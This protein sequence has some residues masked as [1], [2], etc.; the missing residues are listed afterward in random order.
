MG[1]AVGQ[2]THR[3][4]FADVL[5]VPEFRALWFADVQS[6][7]GDQIGRV[8]LSV[9]VFERTRSAGLTGLTYALTYIP[10]IVGGALLS[11]L[12]D[13]LRRRPFMIWCDLS[14]MA[15]LLVM[16]WPR[17]PLS[18]LAALLVVVVIVGRPFQAAENAMLPDILSGEAY[19]VGSGLRTT[20]MQL[21]QLVGFAGGGV[22]VGTVGSHW[23]LFIDAVTFAIS[24]LLI[25]LFVVDRPTPP[26]PAGAEPESYRRTVVSGVRLV[27]GDARLRTVMLLAWLAAFYSVPEGLAAPYAASIGANTPGAVGLLL[28]AIPAGT[29]ISAWALVRRVSPHIR[30]RMMGWLALLAGLPLV[31]CAVGPGLG[32]SLALWVASGLCCGYQVHAAVTFIRLLPERQRAGAYGLAGAGLVAVQGLGILVFGGVAEIISARSAIALAGG[33]GAVLAVP[34][35]LRWRSLRDGVDAVVG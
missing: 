32:V 5:R 29:A 16:S 13:R 19:A 31:A 3:P 15:L 14:R 20:T 10:S 21:S 22:L 12:A 34:L 8:A 33:I 23:G 35:V 9:L 28:A 7:V 30:S 25:R 4:T 27:F 18:V 26:H 24:A 11:P 1:L 2:D 17:L 6:L